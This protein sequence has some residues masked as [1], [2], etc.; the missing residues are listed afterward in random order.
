MTL[1]RRPDEGTDEGRTQEDGERDEDYDDFH[2]FL[3]FFV[4]ARVENKIVSELTGMMI[5]AMSG[6]MIPAKAQTTETEL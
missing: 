3:D 6:L 2:K 5:A 4:P 1:S